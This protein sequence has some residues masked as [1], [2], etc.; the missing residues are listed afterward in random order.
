M[1]NPG[2]LYPNTSGKY[3]P[4]SARAAAASSSSSSVPPLR[5]GSVI[6]LS[7]AAAAPSSSLFGTTSSSS[8]STF[9][10][11]EEKETTLNYNDLRS[12]FDKNGVD[13]KIIYVSNNSEL[14]F[15]VNHYNSLTGAT[16]T[17][18]SIKKVTFQLTQLGKIECVL[19]NDFN[20][21]ET[22]DFNINDNVKLSVPQESSS[23][24]GVIPSSG[25]TIILEANENF[26]LGKYG[27]YVD[28]RPLQN[29]TP[30]NIE[31]ENNY[32]LF[33]IIDNNNS[34]LLGRQIT[35]QNVNSDGSLNMLNIK[36]ETITLK[37]D[38]YIQS[39]LSKTL[40][41]S[42][43]LSSS[44]Q[45]SPAPQSS[46]VVIYTLYSGQKLE[47][48][49]K[50]Q[51]ININNEEPYPYKFPLILKADGNNILSVFNEN[52]KLVGR[53]GKQSQISRDATNINYTR[54]DNN[55]SYIVDIYGQHGYK[56][57]IQ[58]VP[59]EQIL[60]KGESLLMVGACGAAELSL[61]SINRFLVIVL[62][63]LLLIVIWSQR[64]QLCK[65]I[66]EIKLFNRDSPKEPLEK[67]H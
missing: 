18:V 46:D 63:V 1:D 40:A 30:F 4:I 55:Q 60:G 31:A 43:A 50:T 27:F 54:Q 23:T 9:F 48:N 37:K 57:F 17:H 42:T 52:G 51:K 34:E 39:G 38:E 45:P 7:P 58:A 15:I 53:I 29:K 44:I 41:Q 67:L 62:I 64:R 20:E 26:G 59:D 12:H 66:D 22:F 25:N 32:F 3:K 11:D 2:D 10:I 65:F 16:L 8:L 56:E 47:Y 19:L 6:S 21:E 49:D 36:N 61:K 14:L 24:E 33:K 13:S 5:V 35:I 28:D